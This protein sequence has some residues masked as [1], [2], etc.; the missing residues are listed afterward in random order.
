MEAS[1]DSDSMKVTFRGL[2]PSPT[3]QASQN[4]TQPPAEVD[5]ER[6]LSAATHSIVKVPAQE[7]SGATA[8]KVVV[9]PLDICDS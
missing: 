8:K 4:V 1:F 7:F 9:T 6:P 2:I 3:L 5:M